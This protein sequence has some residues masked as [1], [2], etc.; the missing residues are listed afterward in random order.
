MS[1]STNKS[2]C[3]LTEIGKKYQTDKSI[4]HT[5]TELYGRL[6]SREN[7][8]KFLEVG[9]LLGSSLKMWREY[10]P[11]NTI[12]HAID[13]D[14][15]HDPKL[16]NVKCVYGNQDSQE[17]LQE[18]M[19]YLNMNDNTLYDYILDDG[20]HK[21]SQQRNTL[22]VMW[23]YLKSGGIYILEDIHTNI[24]KWYSWHPSNF[25]DQRPTMY[26]DLKNFQEGKDNNL[27][28][29]T[30]EILTTL[31]WSQPEK[32]SMTFLIWKK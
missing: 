12:I 17:S 30:D 13:I 10:F 8:K 22:K 27:P 25:I 31:L 2:S 4:Y 28:I 21:C 19:K 6:L 7:T 23:P 3:E 1:Q 14:L 5:F 11:L 32:T 15:T 9:I 29:N 18:I 20:G 24:E 16:E 26:E